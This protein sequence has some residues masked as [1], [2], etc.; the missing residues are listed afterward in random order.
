[1]EVPGKIIL[2]IK[3]S[4]IKELW[5][6]EVEMG[7]AWKNIFPITPMSY[8]SGTLPLDHPAWGQM[9]NPWWSFITNIP[10]LSWEEAEALSK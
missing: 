1:M 6:C 8:R 5:W 3:S 7:Q 2:Q 4:P 9:P 10:L